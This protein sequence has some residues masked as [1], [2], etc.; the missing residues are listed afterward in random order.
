M[1]VCVRVCANSVAM[2]GLGGSGMRVGEV[3]GGAAVALG[4]AVTCYTLAK[5][6]EK[7][8]GDEG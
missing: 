8:P 5:G 7:S 6:K 4:A 2:L 3:C 1:C